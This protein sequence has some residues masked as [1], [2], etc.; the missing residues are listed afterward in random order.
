MDPDYPLV[1][2]ALELLASINE[3]A[4]TALRVT[5]LFEPVVES[6]RAEQSRLALL[7][8]LGNP[9]MLDR[10]RANRDDRVA[11]D[12]LWAAERLGLEG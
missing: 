2:A 6:R 12:L 7:K 4:A 10:L 3:D 11:Q 9:R 8:A 1:R 5:R